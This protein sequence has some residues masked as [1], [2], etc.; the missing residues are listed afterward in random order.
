MGEKKY[1]AQRKALLASPKNGYDRV[2]EATRK[3]I[4]D[5]AEDYKRFLDTAKTEREAVTDA[6]RRAEAAGFRAWERGM[7]LQPGHF[8]SMTWCAIIQPPHFDRVRFFR[9]LPVSLRFALT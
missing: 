5:Y 9:C 7:A 4:F 1:E 2:D 6:I 8:M 3:A